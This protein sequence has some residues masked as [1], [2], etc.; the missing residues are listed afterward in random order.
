MAGIR[1]AELTLRKP[2]Q[3]YQKVFIVSSSLTAGKM[4]L[5]KIVEKI[6]TISSLIMEATS[7]SLD[8]LTEANLDITIG[9]CLSDCQ[10]LLK[11]K[12]PHKAN[13][14]HPSVPGYKE[15]QE[16]NIANLRLV[17]SS[18]LKIARSYAALL[19][20]SNPLTLK[21]L[22]GERA[23]LFL[24]FNTSVERYLYC[25]MY[26]GSPALSKHNLSEIDFKN[27]DSTTLFST[28]TTSI[29]NA[30]F[31]DFIEAYSNEA[32]LMHDL[33]GTCLSEHKKHLLNYIGK[34]Q[35]IL[36]IFSQIKP[37][38]YVETK[39]FQELKTNFS[40]LSV[41]FSLRRSDSDAITECLNII[42]NLIDAKISAKDLEATLLCLQAKILPQL[43]DTSK[44]TDIIEQL[45][46]NLYTI[47]HDSTSE[48]V[49]KPCFSW[50]EKAQ[51]ALY[52]ETQSKG[53]VAN[54]FIMPLAA[55]IKKLLSEKM[56][57][58]HTK[59]T[60]DPIMLQA[61]FNQLGRFSLSYHQY[62]AIKLPH[63]PT[64]AAKDMTRTTVAADI[65]D[66]SGTS[67]DEDLEVSGT[68]TPH[69]R[70][71]PE[72]KP[73]EALLIAPTVF[74]TADVKPP[75]STIGSDPQAY[76]LEDNTELF[77]PIAR[78]P[79]KRARTMKMNN[80]SGIL[81]GSEFGS[82]LDAAKETP[83]C[84]IPYGL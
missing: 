63:N 47:N 68:L 56:L 4:P 18:Y 31:N 32:N 60:S 15:H 65:I 70:E 81:A 12:S 7:E 80:E 53:T 78:K 82:T 62:D 33:Y 48:V 75:T 42:C 14:F 21:E 64:Y 52:E 27:T 11:D 51:Q 72:F 58:M 35:P 73:T 37:S 3:T 71:T 84:A 30:A 24:D 20:H 17:T 77:A 55:R 23:Q 28:K 25:L 43:T 8:R 50:L 39:P 1:K 57:S 41:L 22:N 67:S 26:Y 19:R 10:R 59:A 49:E 54:D 76:G 46:L 45:F 34:W 40:L 2:G 36:T 13:P 79:Q 61:I 74:N 83:I 44:L 38:E 29:I 66:I 16:N 9:Q 5:D 6:D 69:G